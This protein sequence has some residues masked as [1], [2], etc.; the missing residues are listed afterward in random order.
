MDQRPAKEVRR[1]RRTL[2][3]LMGGIGL[4]A[5][6]LTVVRPY[7]TPAT[8]RAA[9]GILK[10]VGPKAGLNPDHYR[11]DSAVKSPGGFWQVHFVRVAGSGQEGQTVSVPDRVVQ[12]ARFLPW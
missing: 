12:R 6:I 11:A 1:R 10:Q 4:L 8:F 9:N 5:L 7:A 3:S 2:G